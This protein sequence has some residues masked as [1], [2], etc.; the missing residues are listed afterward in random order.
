MFVRFRRSR[1]RLVVSLI[2]SRRVGGQI[3]SEHIAALGSVAL[4]EPV[5]PRE[6]VRFWRD[7]KER[8]RD[9]IERM[10]NRVTQDDRK[11]ALAAIHAR[12]PKPGEADKL[13]ARIERQREDIASL[14]KGC[15]EANKLIEIRRSMIAK[16]ET[17][18]A[19]LSALAEKDRQ[20]IHLSQARLLKLL[21]GEVEA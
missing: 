1:H 6:R 5:G 21:R 3:V 2:E 7:L 4:P 13:D 9:L 18:I 15:G 19:E 16:L 12:I 14:E 11:K 20:A 10:G 8:W 17:D